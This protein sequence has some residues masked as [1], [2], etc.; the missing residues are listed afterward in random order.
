M[1]GERGVL[2]ILG[3]SA[4]IHGKCRK[5]MDNP[6]YKQMGQR[7]PWWHCAHGGHRLSRLSQVRFGDTA[8]PAWGY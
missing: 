6:V 4:I 2:L 7:W 1:A 3:L 5:S 8:A